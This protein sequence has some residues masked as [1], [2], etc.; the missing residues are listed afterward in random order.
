MRIVIHEY[1]EHTV[2]RKGVNDIVVK[3]PKQVTKIV[4]TK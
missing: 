2:V 4:N 3:K 1:G